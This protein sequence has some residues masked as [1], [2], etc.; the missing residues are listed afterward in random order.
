MRSQKLAQRVPSS[1]PLQI[2]AASLL[3][4]EAATS[5]TQY[6]LVNSVPSISAP[7]PLAESSCANLVISF[8]TIGP[9]T[10]STSNDLNLPTGSRISL[11][12]CPSAKR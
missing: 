5:C 1:I 7:S 8:H 6:C 12:T 9:S 4:I 11:L 2:L 10:Q 3:S